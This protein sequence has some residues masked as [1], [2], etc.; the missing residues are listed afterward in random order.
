MTLLEE[1]P[2]E[3]LKGFI[4]LPGGK[5]LPGLKA[6]LHL[7]MCTC[8]RAYMYFFGRSRALS[9]DASICKA[10]FIISGPITHISNGLGW[11]L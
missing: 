1:D 11:V 6:L 4:Y 8:K 3:V 5:E 7:P 2:L 9:K 10:T